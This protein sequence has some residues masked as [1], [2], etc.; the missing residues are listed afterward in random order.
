MPRIAESPLKAQLRTLPRGKLDFVE[1]MKCRLV[2]EPPSGKDWIYEIKFDGIRAIAVKDKGHV[3]LFSR[4]KNDLT[5]RFPEVA[6]AVEALPCQR[7]I[8][9]GEVVALD[10]SGRSSFQLLQSAHMPG[11]RP[12]ICY[13]AFDLLNLEGAD[14]K[15]LPLTR[16]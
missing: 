10:P 15:N 11:A 1:P 12:P 13:Y 5:A 4:L 3:R 16:R 9:D 8:L 6:R 14:L 2:R 7:A